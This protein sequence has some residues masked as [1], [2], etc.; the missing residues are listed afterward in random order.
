MA[1]LLEDPEQHPHEPLLRD[2]PPPPGYVDPTQESA[3]LQDP[4]K[5]EA[6]H[7]SGEPNQRV[8]RNVPEAGPV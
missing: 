6:A 8:K 1:E 3:L 7:P 5:S 2:P 4:S